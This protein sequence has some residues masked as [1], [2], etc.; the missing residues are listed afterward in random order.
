MNNSNPIV[1]ILMTSYNRADF[2]GEAIESVLASSLKEFELI[3]CDDCSI[4]ETVSI[5]NKYAV[6]DS[7]IRVYEHTENVGD[8]PN[9]NRA[10]SY[11]RG[12]YIKYIDSDDAIY[13]HALQIMVD[14]MEKFPEAGFGMSS[15]PESGRHYPVLLNP[16]ET[17]LEHFFGF[18]HF[19]RAPTSVIIKKTA[20]DQVGGFSGKRMIGDYEMWLKMGRIFPMVKFIRELVWTRRHAGQE[21]QSAYAKQY[22][23]LKKEVLKA[24]LSDP[25]C[26]LNA[27][28]VKQV[29]KKI[30]RDQLKDKLQFLLQRGWD[31]F[32]I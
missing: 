8:Y 9:R 7:R 12:K 4:D 1:S 24:A 2:I 6:N 15:L 26:P 31:L 32:R 23:K 14:C 10:A 19:D 3:I 29:Y 30:K 16:K 21:F 25:N 22:P 11:A 17:Y 13:P 20:F 18:G 27:S 28:E 5:A